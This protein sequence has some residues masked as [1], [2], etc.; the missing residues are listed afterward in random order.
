MCR[1]DERGVV[2]NLPIP[3][4]RAAGRTLATFLESYRHHS[5]VLVLALSPDAVPVAYEIASGIDAGLDLFLVR[6][7]P[8]FERAGG[9]PGAVVS[10]FEPVFNEGVLQERKS[11]RLNSS[12]V[13]ISYAVFCLKKKNESDCQ[14]LLTTPRTCM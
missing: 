5:G 8:V 10:D 14:E 3:N 9:S 4:R 2:M 1:Q 13:K 6:E 12:H 11:T 7:L